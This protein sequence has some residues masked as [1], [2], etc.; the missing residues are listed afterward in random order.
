MLLFC[1]VFK[2]LHG[3][4]LRLKTG[5]ASLSLQTAGNWVQPRSNSNGFVWKPLIN[6]KAAAKT[7][8]LGC[9]LEGEGNTSSKCSIRQHLHL[10]IYV[11]LCHLSKKILSLDASLD[12]CCLIWLILCY[13]HPD[14]RDTFVIHLVICLWLIGWHRR[15][16]STMSE[17]LTECLLLDKGSKIHPNQVRGGKRGFTCQENPQY[18]LNI[19]N[20]IWGKL[21]GP[22]VVDS[23][24]ISVSNLSL[25]SNLYLSTQRTSLNNKDV[26]D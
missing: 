16:D 24:W 5:C 21:P 18:L 17:K 13:G 3:K 9:W 11:S 10:S 4:Q 19:G 14:Q 8:F 12:K 26:L 2:Q 15:P 7:H 25:I 22:R 1:F 6:N 20:Y 23:K